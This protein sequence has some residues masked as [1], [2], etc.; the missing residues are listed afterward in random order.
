M[1]VKMDYFDYDLIE[2][3]YI[4]NLIKKDFWVYLSHGSDTSKPTSINSA[5]NSAEFLEKTI[6]AVRCYPKDFSFMIPIRFWQQNE[7]YTEYD[8]TVDLSNKPFFVAVEPEVESGNYHVFKC[9][10]N[11]YGSLSV[12]KPSFNKSIQDGLY[13]VSDGYVWKYM[14]SVPAIE[15]RKFASRGFMPIFRNKIVEDIASEGI[16]NIKVENR[17]SNFGYELLNGEIESIDILTSTITIS[18]IRRLAGT[19]GTLSP[20]QIFDFQINDFYSNRNFRINSTTSNF[21]IGSKSFRILASGINENGKRFFRLNSVDDITEG[22]PFEVTPIIDIK[23]DGTGA[24]A[25]P[26]FENG[27]VVSIRMLNFGNGYKN[28]V[29]RVIPP[30]LGFDPAQGAIEAV[31]RPIVSPK[32]GH[33]KN[34]IRE[35]K[36]RAISI[37]V[38]ISSGQGSE[39][40]NQ[41]SYSKIGLVKEPVFSSSAVF[42]K[43]NI[44][45]AQ[46]GT[47]T[48]NLSSV[49]DLQIGMSVSFMDSIPIKTKII[50]ID[51]IANVIS[52][53]AEIEKRIQEGSNIIFSSVLDSF[54]N[55]IKVICLNK[56]AG[57]EVGEEVTQNDIS[58]RIHSFDTTIIDNVEYDIINLVDY[59]GPFLDIISESQ[60]L[61]SRL[62]GI[63]INSIKYS[64][65][66]QKT[67]DVLYTSDITPIKR[68]DEDVEQLRLVINF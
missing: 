44:S 31:L 37:S 61:I 36:S 34:I 19:D 28:V 8:D 49:N 26:I 33:G 10:S 59:S 9:I 52:L 56:P 51:P 50:G 30:V 14:T 13:E 11:N 43:K 25:I 38:L 22:D 23:G 3:Y 32:G 39:L 48:I 60:P 46:D 24:R 67:G 12:E 63:A 27:R 47:N 55:R 2:N 65:Y 35:L 41:G 15:Y 42:T 57:L 58:A 6:A 40:P 53:S 7:I 62:G 66:I 29:A 68:S 21:M 16:Y 4:D 20:N 17:E 1:T 54:D 5:K 45:V 64:P 18:A